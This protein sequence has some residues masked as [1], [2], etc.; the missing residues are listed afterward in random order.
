MHFD[1]ENDER[2]ELGVSWGSFFWDNLTLV[3]LKW[4][5][6]VIPTIGMLDWEIG[7]WH[8]L[9]TE[10]FPHENGFSRN[11]TILNSWTS[12]PRRLQPNKKVG[13]NQK[14]NVVGTQNQHNWVFNQWEWWIFKHQLTNKSEGFDQQPWNMTNSN[15]LEVR[16]FHS[17]PTN[18]KNS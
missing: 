16:C 11:W 9:K 2:V 13:C 18:L 17:D 15:Q 8:W 12:C 14:N 10:N 6:S 3:Y 7:W 5:H 4:D 1:R